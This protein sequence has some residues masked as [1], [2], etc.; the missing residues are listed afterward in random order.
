MSP[1]GLEPDVLSLVVCDQII[2]DRMTGKQSLIGMFSTIHA[3]RFPA[4]QPQLCVYV[5]MTDGREKTPVTIRIID[6]EEEREPIVSG[7]GVVHFKNPRAIANLALQFHG[8]SFP[9]AGEYRVQL[10]S[11]GTPLREARLHLVQAK[12]RTPGQEETTEG[13]ED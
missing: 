13:R 3:T 11:D 9:K 1:T 2:T 12:R 6:S 8:L 4:T 10:L 5:S 7:Q